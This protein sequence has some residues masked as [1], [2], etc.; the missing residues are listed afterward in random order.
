LAVASQR[1]QAVT[2]QCREIVQAIGVVKH[3]EFSTSRSFNRQKTSDPPI[4]KE[5][6]RVAV[7]E[8]LDQLPAFSPT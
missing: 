8:W 6:L 7:F 5:P 4:L 1:F 3:F 2:R